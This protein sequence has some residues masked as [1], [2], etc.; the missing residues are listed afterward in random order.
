MMNMT[1]SASP[2][3]L[4]Q[5]TLLDERKSYRTFLVPE[6]QIMQNVREVCEKEDVINLTLYGPTVYIEKIK[7]DIVAEN[8]DNINFTR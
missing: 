8:F 4:A 6:K 5:V 1:I 7:N 2:E 3:R